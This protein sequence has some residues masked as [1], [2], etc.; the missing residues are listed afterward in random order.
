MPGF[1]AVYKDM[2]GAAAF[3]KCGGSLYNDADKLF[4]GSAKR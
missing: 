3:E 1:H 4:A 2:T